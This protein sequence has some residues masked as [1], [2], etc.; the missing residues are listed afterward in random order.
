MSYSVLW[1]ENLLH[2]FLFGKLLIF[3]IFE[4]IRDLKQEMWFD[5]LS[6]SIQSSPQLPFKTMTTKLCVSMEM[7]RYKYA[8]INVVLNCIVFRCVVCYFTYPK[9]VQFLINCFLI[10]I[11]ADHSGRTV[12]QEL[13]SP[14]RTLGWGVRIQFEAWM[15]VYVYSVFLLFCV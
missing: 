5:V 13:S 10:Q 11:A 6:V 8:W 3:R 14:F 1:K 4:L 15:S 12:L 7:R 9:F 2:D